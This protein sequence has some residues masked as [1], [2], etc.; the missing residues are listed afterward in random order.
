MDE[1]I[2][3]P[4]ALYYAWA[5]WRDQGKIAPILA[6]S[7]IIML[8]PMWCLISPLWAVVPVTAFKKAV[9][10][11]LTMAICYQVAATMSP[12]RI[13][14]GILL[15]TGIIGV[16]NIVY[17]FGTGDL[18]TGIF[19]Q[20]NYMGKYMVVLWVIAS[21][22]LLDR[23]SAWWI[24]VCASGIAV[25]AVIMTFLSESATAVMLVAVTGLINICGSLF[26]IGGLLRAGRIAA[27]CFCLSLVA[28]AGAIVI[29]SLQKSPVEAV[30]NHFGKD[31]T[32]T[33]R[34]VL[35]DYAED[36]IA[37]EPWLGV[38]ENGFWRYRSSPLVQKLYEEFHKSPGDNFNFH[39]SYY[40]I[41]VHQGL[42][43]LALAVMALIWGAW[44]VLRGA[45]VLAGVAQIYFLT[46][47][48][49]VLA[50]TMTE[51]D[52][53]KPF[54]LF[55][56]ILWIGALSALSQ[57]RSRRTAPRPVSLSGYRAPLHRRPGSI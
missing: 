37:K 46:Q 6:R 24:R 23:G 17:A 45:L 53:L 5:V 33:G 56:M 11:T 25:I 52:F 35:W 54:S 20:K 57:L 16:I 21:A 42:I 29:P 38:G 26:L 51:A 13:L 2:L 47:T 18:R 48:L 34:T 36:Q 14:H 27:I 10:L 19:V 32:L 49:T 8:F 31:T 41:A 44:Q 30:L 12:R 15:A 9:Y 7:W 22:V 39:N 50:R 1:L 43:G 55:H 4:L 40:E 28:G 3:Y